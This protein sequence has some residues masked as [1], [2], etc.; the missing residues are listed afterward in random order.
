MKSIASSTGTH[1]FLRWV[2]PA[3]VLAA[4]IFNS[5]SEVWKKLKWN[6]ESS[7][8][9]QLV[10]HLLGLGPLDLAYN[11]LWLF[12]TMEKGCLLA[13]GVSSFQV[14]S[15]LEM[16]EHWVPLWEGR[17]RNGPRRCPTHPW[18]SLLTSTTTCCLQFGS[19]TIK[20]SYKY[21]VM[22]HV[23]SPPS[24]C[25]PPPVLTAI[26]GRMPVENAE[27]QMGA[28]PEPRKG[29]VLGLSL[30][31]KSKTSSKAIYS[32]W[33][34]NKPSHPDMEEPFQRD[35][36][37]VRFPWLACLLPPQLVLLCGGNSISWRWETTNPQTP[38]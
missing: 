29:F 14:I 26:L 38:F 30:G 5:T 16:K 8:E 37:M 17:F 23:I 31:S 15:L 32:S 13:R 7:F 11:P 9:I 19:L 1:N 18:H 35:W 21:L 10:R 25:S 36:G 33:H 27:C 22:S 28:N 20:D 24:C 6:C 3:K 12:Q 2:M 4:S 34:T